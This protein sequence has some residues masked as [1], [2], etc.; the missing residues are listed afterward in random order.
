MPGDKEHRLRCEL[1]NCPDHIRLMAV[2]GEGKLKARWS[3]Y[4]T[5]KNSTQRDD[6]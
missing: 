6:R 2:D 3:G 5:G 4:L 1:A